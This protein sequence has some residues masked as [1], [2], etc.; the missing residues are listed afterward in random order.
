MLC[1]L[2]GLCLGPHYGTVRRDPPGPVVHLLVSTDRHPR[3]SLLTF[4]HG[5]GGDISP[6]NNALVRGALELFIRQKKWLLQTPSVLPAVFYSF[7]RLACDHDEASMKPLQVRL[8]Q[9]TRILFG[10][11]PVVSSGVQQCAPV[12][13]L[14]T[15]ACCAV[16]CVAMLVSAPA[17][18]FSFPR[19]LHNQ[20]CTPITLP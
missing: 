13:T 20:R 10:C 5:P 6:R 19:R 18:I 7:L 3:A 4:T 9:R 11:F 2:P 16:A 14:E 1:L 12:Y 17:H 8:P 15:V